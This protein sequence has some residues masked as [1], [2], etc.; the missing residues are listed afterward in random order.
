MVTLAKLTHGNGNG[1]SWSLWTQAAILVSGQISILG[2][3]LDLE[4][5]Q[6]D[7]EDTNIAVTMRRNGSYFWPMAH[8]STYTDTDIWNH[9][10]LSQVLVKLKIWWYMTW[11]T[12]LDFCFS[13]LNVELDIDPSLETKSKRLYSSLWS[14]GVDSV[15]S[16][17]FIEHSIKLLAKGIFI[18]LD[19][20][21]TIIDCGFK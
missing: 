21:I 1:S 6:C 9:G 18:R 5:A 20:A 2:D 7:Q 14:S 15:Q 17:L 3:I 11:K 4:E 8:T 19:I 16:C 10:L 12:K 13:P